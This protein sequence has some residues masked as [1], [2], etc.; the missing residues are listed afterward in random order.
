MVTSVDSLE[1]KQ[2]AADTLIDKKQRTVT[3]ADSIQS[4]ITSA[5]NNNVYKE[6]KIAEQNQKLA[7]QAQKQKDEAEAKAKQIEEIEEEIADLQAKIEKSKNEV[8]Q[9]MEKIKSGNYSFWDKYLDRGILTAGEFMG[10]PIGETDYKTVGNNG[11]VVLTGT[12]ALGLGAAYK[13][14]KGISSFLSSNHLSAAIDE[15]KS[16]KRYAGKNDPWNNTMVEHCKKNFKKYFK[17]AV[18][19]S[20]I[21]KR[22]I[23]G[24]ILGIAAIAVAQGKTSEVSN[25]DMAKLYESRI[26]DITEDIENMQNRM[27][28]LKEN[29][30][31]LGGMQ[32]TA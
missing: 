7:E 29:L 3:Y 17:T 6:D 26:K 23:V 30:K 21:I 12:S 27:I 15:I 5:L 28:E 24:S 22:S 11:F 10:T 14:T 13:L 32:K 8:S 2:I 18:K 4:E 19:N 31:R 16:A 20:K 1:Q 25:L 9:R